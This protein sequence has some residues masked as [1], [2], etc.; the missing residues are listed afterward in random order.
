MLIRNYFRVLVVLIITVNLI[1]CTQKTKDSKIVKTEVNKAI[2]LLY[3]TQGS[4]TMGTVTFSQK[5][6]GMLIIADVKGLSP[7]KHGFHIHEYGDCSQPDGKSAGGHFN[8]TSKNHGGPNSEDR[9]VGDLG[10]LIAKDD[11]TAYYEWTDKLLSFSGPKSILGRAIIVHADEDDL[12]SQPTG[13]AG[14]R[15]ACGVIGTAN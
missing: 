7:G 14:A 9:H 11:G 1:S 15:I 6:D 4:E 10:N 13:N 8:P 3:P 2:C 12:I 5:A